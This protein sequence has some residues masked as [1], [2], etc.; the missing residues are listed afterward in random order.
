MSLILIALKVV[1]I[2]RTQGEYIRS[3]FDTED[4]SVTQKVSKKYLM[5]GSAKALANDIATQG[6]NGD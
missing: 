6:F 3:I 1:V 4:Y 2:L 5:D